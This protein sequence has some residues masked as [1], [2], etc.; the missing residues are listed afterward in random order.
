MT[1]AVQC[2]WAL[3]AELGESPVWRPAEQALW[4]VDIKSRLVHRLH[5]DSGERRSWEA[6]EQV[7]F[8]ASAE[9]GGW[10]A[11]LRSG[12]H[13]FDPRTGAFTAWIAIETAIP[14]NRLNDGAVD[15]AGR[16]WFNS[17]DDGEEKPTGVLYRL[18]LGGR[19]DRMDDGPAIT[20]GPQASPDGQTFHHTDTLARTIYAYDVSAA[21]D[22][23]NKRV[24]RR[25][26]EGNGNP[27]GTVIDAAGDLW[28]GKFGGWG[29]DRLS[30]SG[31]LLE[32]VKLPCGNV[33]KGAFGGPDLRT[34]YVTTAKHTLS[35]EGRMAQPEAGDLFAVR[36]ETPGRVMAEVRL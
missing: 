27:D 10:V 15:D 14:G 5:P 3:G 25:F 16:L 21:G 31:D 29:V 19:V 22:L 12:L 26:P 18:T 2:A 4:F 34:L 24:L 13:R 6:P 35:A 33:T 30:P 11:G 7:G 23:S 20:N 9:D 1:R 32:H 36:V 8:I 28:I 17:M